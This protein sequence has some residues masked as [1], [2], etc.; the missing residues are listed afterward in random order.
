MQRIEDFSDERQKSWCIHC[1]RSLA[2]LE[3]NEDRVP[4]KSLLTKPRP[5]HLPVVTICRKCNTGFSLDEQY[6]V[7][8]LS[9][10][11][12]GSTD[13]EKQPNASA[14]RALAE[15]PSLRARIERSRT[16]YVT[17]GGETRIL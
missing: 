10:V 3:T 14:A 13:P 12:A 16:E 2:G 8:F 17:L 5:H 1:A 4:S 6:T 9:S 15:S 11:L 7:T